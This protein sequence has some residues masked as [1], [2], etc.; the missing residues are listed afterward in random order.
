ME[1]TGAV[2]ARVTAVDWDGDITPYIDEIVH[3][4]ESL[5]ALDPERTDFITVIRDQAVKWSIAAWAE[6]VVSDM[7][8]SGWSKLADRL[9]PFVGE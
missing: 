6:E 9:A 1:L 5:I 2:V 4:A 8:D 7:G 3:S